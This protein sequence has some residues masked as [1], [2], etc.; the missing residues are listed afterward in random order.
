MIADD[1]CGFEPSRAQGP[2]ERH[3]G[4]TIMQERAG[5]LNAKLQIRSMRGYGT[6]ISIQLPLGER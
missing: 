1:G 6:T 4:L 2:K 3:F 5:A